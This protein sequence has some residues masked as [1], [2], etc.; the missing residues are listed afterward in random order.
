MADNFDARL[1]QA[2]LATNDDIAD[3]IK[4][5]E[6]NE[7]LKKVSKIVTSNKTRHAKVEEKLQDP[8]KKG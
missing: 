6:V 2:K 4:E 7:K 3:F 8:A 5:A 1:K